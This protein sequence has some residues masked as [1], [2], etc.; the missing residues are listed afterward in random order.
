MSSTVGDDPLVSLAQEIAGVGA[1]QTRQE[2][3]EEIIRLRAELDR[4]ETRARQAEE[5]LLRVHRAIRAA[6]DDARSARDAK[7]EILESAKRFASE[8]VRQAQLEADEVRKTTETSH[9]HSVVMRPDLLD[10]DGFESL[11]GR[12]EKYL[13]TELEP[14]RSRGWILGER[15]G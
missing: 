15:A 2:L 5:Q 8:L 13:E 4:A 7:N 14:D 1:G 9:A 12:F 11:D 6:K 10:E 3:R